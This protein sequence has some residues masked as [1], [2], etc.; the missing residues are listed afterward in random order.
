M[1][2]YAKQDR[3]RSVVG[4]RS[5]HVEKIVESYVLASAEKRK[6]FEDWF[7]LLTAVVRALYGDVLLFID[8]KRCPVCNKEFRNRGAALGHFV[9]SHTDY[10]MQIV[11]ESTETYINLVTRL[12]RNFSNIHRG[13]VGNVCLKGTRT[14][15]AKYIL[16]HPE[17]LKQL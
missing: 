15:I 16:K 5:F 1:G 11:H 13:F 9:R 7:P 4:M 2:V 10:W 14:M 8:S 12:T 17:I 6:R 3:G